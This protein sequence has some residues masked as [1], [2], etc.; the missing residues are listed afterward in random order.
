MSK[1]LWIKTLDEIAAELEDAG[2]SEVEA[3]EAA[4]NLTDARHRDRLADMID[5]AR[6][7]A[8]EKDIG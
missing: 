7:E 3:Y 4:A 8:K 5:Q 1:E 6:M 2:L